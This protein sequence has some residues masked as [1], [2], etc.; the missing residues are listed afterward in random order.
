MDQQPTT[1]GP[2][3]FKQDQRVTFQIVDPPARLEGVNEGTVYDVDGTLKVRVGP[4]GSAPAE[5]LP[6]DALSNVEPVKPTLEDQKD[7]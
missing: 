6:L 1:S 7:A 5:Y 2:K 3:R 4:F